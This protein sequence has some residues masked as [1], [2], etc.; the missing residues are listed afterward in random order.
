MKKKLFILF[1]P[2]FIIGFIFKNDI[3]QAY[4]S[5][6]EKKIISNSIVWSSQR[7]LRIDDFNFEPT[8]TQMDNVAVT[9]GIV[10]V[11]KFGK[12]INHRS[13]TVFQPEYSFITDKKDSLVLRIA[14]ARFDLCE[15][16][17]R[18]MELKIDSLNKEDITKINSDTITKYEELYYNLFENEWTKFNEI[19]TNH[20]SSSLIKMENYLLDELK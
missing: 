16:Y 19:T 12:R 20:L 17:R 18:K 10:S 6:K 4:F 1:I 7:K 14:Q 15:L 11:H 9:V 5:Y 13:T 8:K 2:L 3:Q